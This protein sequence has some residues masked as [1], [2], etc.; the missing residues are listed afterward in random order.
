MRIT[1]LLLFAAQYCSFAQNSRT[2]DERDGEPYEV[3]QIGD[4]WWMNE[5]LCFRS[6]LS[7]CETT[8]RKKSICEQTNFYSRFELDTICPEG[9]RI[10]TLVD[11]ETTV[12]ILAKKYGGTTSEDTF[13]YSDRSELI[14]LNE[15]QLNDTSVLSFPIH[16]G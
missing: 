8:K 13:Y 4:L 2:I 16:L 12:D 3:V 15:F 14:H 10:P 11:W 6:T 5:D 1:V 9:W 7:Y